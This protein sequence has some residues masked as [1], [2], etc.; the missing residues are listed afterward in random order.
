MNLSQNGEVVMK[1]ILPVGPSTFQRKTGL[2]FFPL[3]NSSCF[4]FFGAFCLTK[5]KIILIFWEEE[6]RAVILIFIFLG[7]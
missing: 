5:G 3:Q 7:N 2:F 1:M 6:G 4:P